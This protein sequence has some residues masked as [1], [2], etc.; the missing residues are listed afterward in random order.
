MA[1]CYVG[2]F[3]TMRALVASWEWL[4]K[5]NSNTHEVTLLKPCPGCTT[6]AGP[7][8]AYTWVH[9]CMCVRVCM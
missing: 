4:E 2:L 8:G 1:V 6:R 7:V 5:E 3:A 9:V